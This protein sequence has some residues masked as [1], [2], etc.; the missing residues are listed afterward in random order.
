LRGICETEE[1]ID[2][3]YIFLRESLNNSQ[4]EF[5]GMSG[6]TVLNLQMTFVVKQ[7]WKWKK[8]KKL[9]CKADI[10]RKGRD[11]DR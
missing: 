6:L 9:N 3:D 8:M 7:F 1:D 4:Y 5:Q 10:N 11:G 2:L